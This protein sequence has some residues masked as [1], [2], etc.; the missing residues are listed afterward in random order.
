MSEE[1][2]QRAFGDAI[3]AALDERAGAER[4]ERTQRQVRRG[5]VDG[6]RPL[7]FDESGFPV[8]QRSAGFV[9]RV[10]RLLGQY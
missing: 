10:A 4:Y 7:E 5:A 3:S 6:P 9:A 2:R 8:A 1:A